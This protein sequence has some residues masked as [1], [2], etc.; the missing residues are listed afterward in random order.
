MPAFSYQDMA[1]LVNSSLERAIMYWAFIHVSF[2][3]SNIAGDLL[4][5]ETSKASHSSESEKISL[6]SPGFQPRSAT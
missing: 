4:M 1:C 6:S 3:G 5:P 2:S